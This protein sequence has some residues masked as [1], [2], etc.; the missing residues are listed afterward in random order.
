MS[1]AHLEHRFLPNHLLVLT[2]TNLLD[3]HY[4]LRGRNIHSLRAID[5]RLM[6]KW[7][8]VAL[9]YLRCYVLSARLWIEAALVGVSVP[10]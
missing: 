1:H 2:N 9:F 7:W 10:H 4:A 5:T 8:G 3:H 6:P